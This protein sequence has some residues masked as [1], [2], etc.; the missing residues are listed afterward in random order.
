MRVLSFSALFCAVVIASGCW[1]AAI[2]RFEKLKLP[3]SPSEIEGLWLLSE[4][5]RR[6]IVVDHGRESQKQDY[7]IVF[8]KDGVCSVRTVLAGQY[9]NADG[10]WSLTTD[11]ADYYEHR[12]SVRVGGHV[13][14]RLAIALDS[15]ETVIF[16]P[17]GDPDEGGYL[18]YRRRNNGEPVAHANRPQPTVR[19]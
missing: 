13:F 17:W 19:P 1:V 18:I 6:A 14:T 15:G 9:F 16:E 10:H 3:P 12:L 8:R 4:E 11:R 7:S 5:S 2:P